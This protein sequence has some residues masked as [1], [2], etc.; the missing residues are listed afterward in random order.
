MNGPQTYV[1]ACN[2]PWATE[3]FLLRR[4]SLPGSWVVLADAADLK[5]DLLQIISPRYIF[6]PHWSHLVPE[7]VW[8]NHECVCFHM[9][10][11]PFGRGGSPLQNLIARGHGETVLTA[12]RMTADLDA[13]P[14]Y[15]K[16][17]LSLHGSAHEIYRRAT[18]LAFDCMAWMAAEHPSPKPQTGEATSFSRRT[19]DQSRLPEGGTLLSLYDHIRMLD[20]PGYP[21]AFL[22]HGRWRISFT[23]ACSNEDGLTVRARIVENGC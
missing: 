12:L 21:H 14:V 8:Q 2:R 22:Q 7:G 13:G 4:P 6:F 9:T 20:A 11:V 17:P 18:E 5:P 15:D 10:D 1:L 16:R 3:T 19:P 23:D